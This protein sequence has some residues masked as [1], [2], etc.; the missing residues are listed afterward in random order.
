MIELV[1]FLAVVVQ[2]SYVDVL[3]EY[4]VRYG[5]QNLRHVRLARLLDDALRR[6]VQVLEQTIVPDRLPNVEAALP[7]RAIDG[8]GS[9]VQSFDVA[10]GAVGVV[11]CLDHNLFLIGEQVQGH[12]LAHLAVDVLKL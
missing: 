1:D 8:H 2:V 10:I 5:L 6:L 3:L 7:S 9:T 11:G 4:L 12:V